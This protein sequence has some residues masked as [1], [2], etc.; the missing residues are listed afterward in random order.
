MFFFAVSILKYHSL[1]LGPHICYWYTRLPFGMG[2]ASCPGG[3]ASPKRGTQVPMIYT[4]MSY[5]VQSIAFA[6]AV[7]FRIPGFEA[8]RRVFD[9]CYCI[10]RVKCCGSMSCCCA[11]VTHTYTVTTGTKVR[12]W[13]AAAVASLLL[14]CCIVY[15][16]LRGWTAAFTKKNTPLFFIDLCAYYSTH[17]AYRSTHIFA[18]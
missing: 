12:A 17:S 1:I 4:R 8:R 10:G 7:C 13:S 2:L 5:T 11:P 9:C 15:L 16:L 18:R 14:Y 3:V 6:A